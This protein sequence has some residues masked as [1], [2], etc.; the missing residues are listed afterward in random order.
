VAAATANFVCEF[1]IC[2]QNCSAHLHDALKTGA[3]VRSTLLNMPLLSVVCN[4][5]DGKRGSY[6]NQQRPPRSVSV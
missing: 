5:F 6:D 3:A 2:D 1:H 4:T